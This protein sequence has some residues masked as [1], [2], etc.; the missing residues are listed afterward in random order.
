MEYLTDEQMKR[1]KPIKEAYTKKNN[2][3]QKYFGEL[4]QYNGQAI[5]KS[6]SGNAINVTFIPRR[7]QTIILN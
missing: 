3:I 2:V 6:A 1:E 4:G 7:N 5:K